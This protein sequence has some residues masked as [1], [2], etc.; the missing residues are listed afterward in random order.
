MRAVNGGVGDVLNI[1]QLEASARRSLERLAAFAEWFFAVGNERPKHEMD[2]G[3]ERRRPIALQQPERG[4]PESVGD[5][6]VS[7][8]SALNDAAVDEVL[9]ADFGDAVT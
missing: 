9:A 1:T 3:F 7:E 6:V 2:A 4:L 8:N 5:L